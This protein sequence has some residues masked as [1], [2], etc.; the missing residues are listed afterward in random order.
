MRRT[1]IAVTCLLSSAFISAS[2]QEPP[3]NPS[4][5][6][7]VA[8]THEIKP[9]RRTIALAGVRQGFNQLHLTLTV[10]PSGEVVAAEASGDTQILKFWPQLEEEVRQ[11]KFTPFEKNGK[12]LTA[13]VEEYLDLVPPERLPQKHL[14][15]PILHPDSEVAISLTRSGCFGSCPSYTVTVST[16]GITFEGR[17]FVVASG[18]HSDTVSAD[19]VRKLA[20]RFV[21]A[22]FYSMD[23]MY[24]ASVTDCPTYVLSIEIDGHAKEVEDYMGAWEGMPEV[25]AELED[26]VDTV[27][28]TSR[29]IEGGDGLVQVLE[30]EKYNFKTFGGQ[31]MAKESAARGMANTVRDLLEAGVPLV[32]TPRRP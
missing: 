13:E 25:I 28:R 10:S 23:A 2:A 24:R 5:D 11:W 19:E 20:A 30:A 15:A 18:R 31:I 16:E 29:W 14:A 8:H 22:D 12:A 21:A 4:Y 7:E 27:A 3:S 17:G 32:P 9:H 6:Y 1:T 26:E